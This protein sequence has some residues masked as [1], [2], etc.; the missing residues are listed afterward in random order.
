MREKKLLTASMKD[1][2]TEVQMRAVSLFER[3]SE[4]LKQNQTVIDQ[5]QYTDE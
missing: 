1:I 4:W 3:R 2:R 5:V